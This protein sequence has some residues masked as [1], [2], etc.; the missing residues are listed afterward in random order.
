MKLNKFVYFAILFI[1]LTTF[2]NGNIIIVSAETLNDTI[3]EQLENLDFSLIEQNIK[4]NYFE[5]ASFYNMVL[6]LLKGDYQSS[7]TSVFSYIFEIFTAQIKELI[8]LIISVICV[9][10][11][12]SIINGLK[13]NFLQEGTADL[14]NLFAIL[15]VFLIVSSEF[16]NVFQNTQNIIENIS[17]TNEIMS[18][19]ILALMVASGSNTSVAIYKPTV[20]ILSN[21]VIN[22][23]NFVILPIVI[24]FTILSVMNTFNRSIRLNKFIEL[25]TSIIKWA[26]GIVVTVYTFF[27]S[28]QGLSSAIF[29]GVSIKA[30]KYALSNSIPI[31]GGFVKDGFDLF[32]AGSILIKNAV[33]VVGLTVIIGYVLSP[34]VYIAVFSLLLK[35]CAGFTETINDGR[36]SN[37]CTALSKSLSYCNVCII[38]VSFMMFVTVLLMIISASAFV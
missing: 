9:A 20:A 21:V 15:S 19:I 14:I 5:E 10:I 31:I 2:F 38:M 29:D 36:I 8:P 4:D 17:K 16:I 33:G 27:L 13:G 30:T 26:I 6:K 37:L 28:I 23:F 1:I 11:I 7:V 3:I 34:I 24:I 25:S 18:P 22:V 12:C 32:L 35:L